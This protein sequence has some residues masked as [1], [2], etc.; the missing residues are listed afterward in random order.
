MI[1]PEIKTHFQDKIDYEKWKL[2]VTRTTSIPIKRLKLLPNI[3]GNKESLSL[4]S[5][6]DGHNRAIVVKLYDYYF[7]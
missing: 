5:K 1:F 7:Y 2:G 3:F 6:G 4:E